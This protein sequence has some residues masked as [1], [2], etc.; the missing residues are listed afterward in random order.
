MHNLVSIIYLVS[1]ERAYGLSECNCLPII[2]QDFSP[3]GC[4]KPL[5]LFKGYK[6]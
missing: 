6:R 3:S 5:G 4:T 2:T 1:S